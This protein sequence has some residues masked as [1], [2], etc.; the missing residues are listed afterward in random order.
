VALLF[1]AFGNPVYPNQAQGAYVANISLRHTAADAAG[2]MVWAFRNPSS[3]RTVYLR[4]IMAQLTFDGTAAA[5]TGIGYEF[6]RFTTADP[7]TGTTVPRVKRFGTTASVI[8]DAN[9]QQK[10]GILTMTGI[11]AIE[12]FHVVRLSVSVTSGVINI[13]LPYE[14]SGLSKERM[15]FTSDQGFGIRVG[16]VAAIIGQ[17]LSGSVHW[18]EVNV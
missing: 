18:D 13:N 16:P 3:I 9:I 8:L 14:A 15:E 10:S 12:I 6:V 17:T 4:K 5:A 7:T 11:L 2:S 1:D